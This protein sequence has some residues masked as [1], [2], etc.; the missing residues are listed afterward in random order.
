M[1]KRDSM[2][3]LYMLQRMQNVGDTIYLKK[4]NRSDQLKER[5][6]GERNH[7]A[8][9]RFGFLA[10]LNWFLFESKFSICLGKYWKY[11]PKSTPCSCQG[12]SKM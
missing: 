3:F 2:S 10:R 11:D 6:E 9:K 8:I 1:S 7:K 5:K 12:T 4:H